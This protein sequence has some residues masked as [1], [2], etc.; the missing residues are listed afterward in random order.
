MDVSVG[1][2]GKATI[3]IGEMHQRCHC[4]LHSPREIYEKCQAGSCAAVT[5][6]KMVLE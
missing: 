6:G 4:G 2:H 3:I 1:R 5:V